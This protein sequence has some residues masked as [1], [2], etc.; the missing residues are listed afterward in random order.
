MS[1]RGLFITIEGCEGAGKSTASAFVREA[2]Q[3]ANIN[4]VCT[5]EPGGT[6][7]GE[8]LR[9]I[10]LTPGDTAITPTAELLMMFAAR[11]QHLQEVIKPAISSGSWVLCDRFTDASYAYQ[12]GGRELGNAPVRLLEDMVQS[13]LRPDLTIL[14]DVPVEIGLERARG[15]GALDRFE[16]E[17]IAF[18]NRVRNAYLQK[19]RSGSGRY[20]IVDASRDL[21]DVQAD[22]GAIAT[23]L[24]ACPPLLES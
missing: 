24:V 23:E 7:L 3:N 21:Q 5:R 15:R 13:R 10:L 17:D 12:G 16:Q 22:L 1:E 8:R 6:P 9:E 11:A 19:A 2:L 18:F 20:R 14:M 4:L